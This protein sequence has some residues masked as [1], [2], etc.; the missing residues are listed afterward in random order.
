MRRVIARRP[1]WAEVDGILII[2]FPFAQKSTKGVA[3]KLIVKCDY[4]N[5][6]NIKINITQRHVLSLRG[7]DEQMKKLIIFCCIAVGLLSM[8]NNVVANPTFTEALDVYTVLNAHQD[9]WHVDPHTY[10]HTYDGSVDPLTGG[11]YGDGT[12]TLTIVADDVDGT[13][14]TYPPEDDPVRIKIDDGDWISLGN[15]VDMD[16]YTNNG[17]DPGAGNEDFPGSITTTVFDL[18]SFFDL[19][20]LEGGATLTVEIGVED[21]WG[22]EIETSTLTI[23]SA[24]PAP[25]AILLGSLGVGLVGWLRRRRTL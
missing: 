25:G 3:A 19:S 21:R 2:S 9:P 23:V 11:Y 18:G 10:D 8:T 5:K 6:G 20:L 17:W 13:G 24:I 1:F 7:G 16:D 14:G 22:F 12:A 15:L 4:V